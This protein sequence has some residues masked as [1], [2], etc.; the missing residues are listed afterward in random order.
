M[1]PNRGGCDFEQASRLSW[2]R[3]RDIPALFTKTS[4]GKPN[5]TRIVVATRYDNRMARSRSAP[6]ETPACYA[7]V[8]PGLEAIAADEITRD[9]GGEVRKSERGL[10]I[11]RV[12]EITPALLK[13]RTVEDVYLLAWGTDSLTYRAVDL[14]QIRHWTAKEADWQQLLRLHHAVHPKPKGKPTYHLVAQMI[15]TH[16]YRRIDAKKEMALGLAGVFPAS[17]RPAEEDAAVEI[18]LTIQG[19][20]AVCGIRLSDKTMRHRTWKEEHLPASLRPTMAAAM[21]RLAGAAGGDFVLDPMCGAGTILGE[22]IELSKLRKAGRVEVLGGDFDKTALRAAAANLKRVGPALIAQW[23]ATRLPLAVDSVDRIISNPPFGKQLSSPEEIGP[24]Y[25]AMI[26]ECDRALKNGG[27][28]VFLVSEMQPL[29]DA[30]RPH[31]WEALKQVNV[32]VLGQAA[33]ISVWRKGSASATLDGDA[34][35]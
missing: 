6:S 28:A 8:L 34:S 14:K 21:V 24:L 16:A 33:T 20:T 35:Y 3:H 12:K 17:W 25:R 19:K 2:E 32:R 30:I 31:G 10:V 1:M 26:R 7:I 18:W 5:R 9:L 13:L 15:G 29:R 27:K 4:V 11:F 22:Q 23:D